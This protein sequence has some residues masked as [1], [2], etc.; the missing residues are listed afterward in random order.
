[1]LLLSK[2]INIKMGTQLNG[3]SK[4]HEK[5]AQSNWAFIKGK[6]FLSLM[7][8]KCSLVELIFYNK[9]NDI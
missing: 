2:L 5:N 6:L 4:F 8:L 9:K 1:M 3:D 7:A